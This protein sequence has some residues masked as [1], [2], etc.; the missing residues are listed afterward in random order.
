MHLG[1]CTLVAKVFMNGRFICFASI[2]LNSSFSKIQNNPP[3][4]LFFQLCVRLFF[5]TISYMSLKIH[6]WILAFLKGL[7]IFLSSNMKHDYPSLTFCINK[8][9]KTLTAKHIRHLYYS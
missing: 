3:G 6:E 5:P 1:E 7:V 4:R 8:K 2:C 9:N